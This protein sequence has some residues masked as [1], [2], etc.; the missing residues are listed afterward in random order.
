MLATSLS[1]GPSPSPWLFI[2][3]FEQKSTD[4]VWKRMDKFWDCFSES[5]YHLIIPSHLQLST[6][7][8]G[9]GHDTSLKLSCHFSFNNSKVSA[10]PLARPRFLRIPFMLSE[11]G[12][13]SGKVDLIEGSGKAKSCLVAMT[14]VLWGISLSMREF[15]QPLSF[16]RTQRFPSFWSHL[17]FLTRTCSGIYLWPVG[18]LPYKCLWKT[19]MAS[20]ISLGEGRCYLLSS[21]YS[22][23]NVVRSIGWSFAEITSH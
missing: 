10:L 2:S 17:I 15:D 13:G 11:D 19:L 16:R 22:T 12:K 1:M 18:R 3:C 7:F 20:I 23:S 8:V 4:I 21:S 14:K 5:V 9:Q 6:G